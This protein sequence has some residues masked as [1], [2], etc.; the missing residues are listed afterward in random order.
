MA[1]A[2]NVFRLQVRTTYTRLGAGGLEALA[3]VA[4]CPCGGMEK[5][6]TVEAPLQQ[7][8]TKAPIHRLNLAHGP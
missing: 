7:K 2:V 1:G 3:A 4:T 5:V 6:P 8:G